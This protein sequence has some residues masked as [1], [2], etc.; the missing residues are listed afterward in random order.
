MALSWKDAATTGLAAG[1]GLLTYAKYQN[2]QGWLTGP[3]LGIIVLGVVGILM[4]A[5]G[6]GEPMSSGSI[7]SMGL[8]IM[9]GLALV[10]IIVGLI[11]GGRL[12]FYALAADILVLW[13]LATLRH[14]G[15]LT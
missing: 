12:V 14:A 8:S 4:C 3:R 1:T 13:L 11:T 15:G 10:L 7:W 5:L 9:G 2:W 6:A